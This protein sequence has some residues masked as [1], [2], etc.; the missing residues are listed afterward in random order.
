MADGRQR[1]CYVVFPHG[2]CC[3]IQHFESLAWSSP[4]IFLIFLAILILCG[5][6]HSCLPLHPSHDTIPSIPH[7]LRASEFTHKPYQYAVGLSLQ[8]VGSPQPEPSSPPPVVLSVQACN[9]LGL[10]GGMPGGVFRGRVR[11][12]YV[13]IR[14]IGRSGR[15]GGKIRI[16]RVFM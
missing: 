7:R 6:V 9:M 11:T 15:I 3:R 12:E 8:V 1:R 10:R 5:H 14:R 13:L 16:T 2:L 4:N